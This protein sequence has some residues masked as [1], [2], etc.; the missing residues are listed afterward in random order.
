VL[1]HRAEILQVEKEESLVVRDFED[2]VEHACLRLVQ[3]EHAGEQQRADFGNG[4]AD[5]VAL[6]AESIPEDRRACFEA[7]V[8]QLERGDAFL[9]LARRLPGAADAGEIAFD[10]R[11]EHRNAD[12]AEAFG[13]P[14]Q[15][16]C[17]PGT[18]RAR[19]QTVAIGELRKKLEE[20][21]GFRYDYGLCHRGSRE[22]V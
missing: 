21:A 4:R 10:V 15:R 7:E 22:A 19:D 17:L 8:F 3:V 11:H 18:G 14:L 6:L 20:L 2:S 1:Q 12:P 9:D 16:H 13:E 5:L